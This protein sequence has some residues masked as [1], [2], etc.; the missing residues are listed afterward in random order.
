MDAVYQCPV[1]D[2]QFASRGRFKTHLRGKCGNPC[3]CPD[4]CGWVGT[5]SGLLSHFDRSHCTPS[6]TLHM[7][8]DTLRAVLERF[9]LGPVVGHP[10]YGDDYI[11]CPKCDTWYDLN[12]WDAEHR[13]ACW[14]NAAILPKEATR[15]KLAPSPGS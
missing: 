10:E 13:E 12:H 7:R 9:R 1:C 8:V 6:K 3:Y 5:Y 14:E 15:G 4:G 11:L 2:R